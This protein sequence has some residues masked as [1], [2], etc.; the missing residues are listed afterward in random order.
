MRNLISKVYYDKLLNHKKSALQYVLKEYNNI[1]KIS[2][3]IILKS[4]IKDIVLLFTIIIAI[5]IT[6]IKYNT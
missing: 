4:Y 1:I 6:S 2:L 3:K 5:T